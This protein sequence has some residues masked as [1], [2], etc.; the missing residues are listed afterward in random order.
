MN[1]I[2]GFRSCKLS[3]T[4]L[5]DKVDKQT[6]EIFKNGNIPQLHVPARPNHDYDLLIGEL[7]LRF[8]SMEKE[9]EIFKK[10]LNTMTAVKR[11]NATLLAEKIIAIQ[12]LGSDGQKINAL[13]LTAEKSKQRITKLEKELEAFKTSLAFTHDGEF[14][15]IP[16]IE[17][18]SKPFQNILTVKQA[19]TFHIETE[20]EKPCGGNC[21]KCKCDKV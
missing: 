12:L 5:F 11:E 7:L 1:R 20:N 2:I 19:T 3:N 17:K 13:K 14:N 15:R 18:S 10:D 6:D 16:T 21:D 8:L 9:N 4:E